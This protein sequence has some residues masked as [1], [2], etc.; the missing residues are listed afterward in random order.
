M[1]NPGPEIRASSGAD[2]VAKG[3]LTR[4]HCLLNRVSDGS[5]RQGVCEG[6]T[7]G[8]GSRF[9]QKLIVC[10]KTK[11]SPKGRDFEQTEPQHENR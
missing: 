6:F 11:G 8:K 5:T 4:D 10:S 3:P 2:V 1:R 9:Y 7:R